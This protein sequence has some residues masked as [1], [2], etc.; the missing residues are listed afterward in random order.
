MVDYWRISMISFYICVTVR[1]SYIESG[2]ASFVGHCDC[3]DECDTVVDC[4]K[5]RGVQSQY[6]I[7]RRKVSGQSQ[8]MA[9]MFPFRI[10]LAGS[11]I[12]MTCL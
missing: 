3:K 5:K 12:S 10:Q 1:V 6:I 4:C 11:S 8:V 9:E 2:D 7:Y